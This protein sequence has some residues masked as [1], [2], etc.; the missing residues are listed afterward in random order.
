MPSPAFHY[1]DGT[2]RWES[3]GQSSERSF[4]GWSL[5][6]LRVSGNGTG[7]LWQIH[8][9]E[10]R[11]GLNAGFVGA[12]RREWQRVYRPEEEDG[13]EGA[14]AGVMKAGFVSMQKPEF[15]GSRE[16]AEGG[17]CAAAGI[18][19]RQRFQFRSHEFVLDG[20]GASDA[21]T[22]G[23]HLFDRALLAAAAGSKRCRY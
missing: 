7:F 5:G 10:C 15:G 2:R 9:W 11:G 3:P 18:A 20:P 14:L 1:D 16:F 22:G 8:I 13:V 6:H 4:D 23:A 17:G 19:I 21:P 12:C